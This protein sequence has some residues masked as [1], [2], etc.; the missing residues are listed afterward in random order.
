M[1][2][3][4]EINFTKCALLFHQI[5]GAAAAHLSYSTAIA[6]FRC[7]IAKQSIANHNKSLHICS[8][9]T[10][11]ASCPGSQ[12]SLWQGCSTYTGSSMYIVAYYRSYISDS[13]YLTQLDLSLHKLK[14]T[15]KML[16]FRQLQLTW[17]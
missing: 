2:C 13:Y 17:Y 4:T 9:H 6:T 10:M 5:I 1:N 3:F 11:H 8:M 7:L 14:E 12:T 15:T 16:L